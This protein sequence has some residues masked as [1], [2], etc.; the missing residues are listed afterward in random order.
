M[1]KAFKLGPLQ[2]KWLRTL[3]KYP[4]R[5]ITGSLGFKT[6]N[7]Y[8]ACCLGAA[9]ICYREFNRMMMPFSKDGEILSGTSGGALIKDF[10]K[11][12]LRNANGKLLESPEQYKDSLSELNDGGWSWPK[13]AKYIR[14]NPKNV[15]TKSV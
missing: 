7:S 4:R 12:G 10:R 13:I 14:S 3:E 8:K 1:P 15:F 6:K 11:I 2:L 5:K 9:L